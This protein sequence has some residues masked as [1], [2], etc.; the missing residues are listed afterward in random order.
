MDDAGELDNDE[1]GDAENSTLDIAGEHGSLNSCSCSLDLV[2]MTS[3]LKA[4]CPGFSIRTPGSK[5]YRLFANICGGES[6]CFISER[7]IS[8][9]GTA[10]GSNPDSEQMQ[11]FGHF[12]VSLEGG[13]S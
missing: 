3:S 1:R 10:G 8:V 13:H 9:M 4:S 7:I 2:E 5:P 6:G 12:G 11:R